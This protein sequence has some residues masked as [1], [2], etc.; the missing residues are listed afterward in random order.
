[1][2]KTWAV[3]IQQA[4]IV[5]TPDILACVN[6]YFVALELKRDAKSKT[7]PIQDYNIDK[8][9]EAGGSALIV[10]PSSWPE[11]KKLLLEMTVEGK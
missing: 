5:G 9:N 7:T 1:M 11:Y 3:K 2:P 4:S 6:G 10:C 8:I